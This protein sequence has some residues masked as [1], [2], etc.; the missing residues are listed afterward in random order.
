MKVR[1]VPFSFFKEVVEMFRIMV[2]VHNSVLLDKGTGTL[3]CCNKLLECA[4]QKQIT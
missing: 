4:G 1:F 3:T 2:S